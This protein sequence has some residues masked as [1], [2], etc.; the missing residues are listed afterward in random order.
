MWANFPKAFRQYALEGIGRASAAVVSVA[1]ST[2]ARG[3][4]RTPTPIE[5]CDP[6]ICSAVRP[7]I[8]K[9]TDATQPISLACRASGHADDQCVIGS[10]SLSVA[11]QSPSFLMLLYQ[12]PA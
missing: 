11:T 9:K 1:G 2:R 4:W 10:T 7:R 12:M 5:I 3:K 8:F 6:V